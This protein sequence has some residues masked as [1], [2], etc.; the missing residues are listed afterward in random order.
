M[1][2]APRTLTYQGREFTSVKALAE[3]LASL[4]GRSV[5]ALQ[6]ALYRHRGDVERAIR[7][8]SVSRRAIP[9]T[10]QGRHF[11]S[12]KALAN[13]FA[14]ILGKSPATLQVA[15]SGCNGDITRALRPRTL[16]RAIPAVYQGR[17]FPSRSALAEHLA[18]LIGL[19]PRTVAVLLSKY[20]GDAGRI[21][22]RCTLRNA[23]SQKR[24][25]R[26]A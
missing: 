3:H 23:A 10:Y 25:K 13:H 19:T 15:L 11:P 8:R 12:K 16:A 14:P 24:R 17:Q 4:T 21:F 2:P 9:C 6:Q 1:P 7:P 18:P 22:A 26:P 5:A 20:D